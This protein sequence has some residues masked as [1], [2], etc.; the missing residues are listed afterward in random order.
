MGHRLGVLSYDFSK[1][2]VTECPVLWQLY[3]ALVLSMNGDTEIYQA[4]SNRKG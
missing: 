4:A 2:R 3:A 1:L